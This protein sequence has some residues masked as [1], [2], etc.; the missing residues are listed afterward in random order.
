V[1]S[2]AQSDPDYLWQAT[3]TCA[4]AYT[5]NNLNQYPTIAWCGGAAQNASWDGNGNLHT[6]MLPKNSGSG[7]DS[8]TYGYD[9][10][11]RLLTAAKTGL[12]VTYA[13]DPLDHRVSRAA[14]G[15]TVLPS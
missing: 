6:A 13:Y 1:A 9:P 4:D 8:W 14:T 2:T 5:Q 11:N 10:E 7:L 3:G 12:T 15:A